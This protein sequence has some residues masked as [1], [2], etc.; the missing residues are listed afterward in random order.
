MRFTQKAGLALAMLT[1]VGFAAMQPAQAQ[2]YDAAADFSR[3]HNPNGVWS[4]GQTD[5]L[6][7]SFSLFSHNFFVKINGGPLNIWFNPGSNSAS[8]EHNGNNHAVS[9]NSQLWQADGLSIHAGPYG[10]Y[11]IVRFTA[12]K[13]DWYS[14]NSSF[15]AGDVYASVDVHILKDLISFLDAPFDGNT[16]VN[17]VAPIML[18]KGETL[19]FAVGF[20]ANQNYYSDDAGL[21]VVI[22]AMGTL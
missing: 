11:G 9:F 5:A 1:I 18:A 8:V 12:P 14:L 15:Y 17:Y 19:D 2:T 16:S 4:Y 3:T 10:Q 22:T 6:G 20:G 13:T 7:S 21:K